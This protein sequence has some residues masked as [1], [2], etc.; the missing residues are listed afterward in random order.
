MTRIMRNHMGSVSRLM[1]VIPFYTTSF[2]P[3]YTTSFG[4]LYTTSFGPLS[5]AAWRHRI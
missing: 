1:P 5:T 2:G 4:P 3:F